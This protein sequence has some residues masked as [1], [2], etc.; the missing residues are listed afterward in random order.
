[1]NQLVFR[2]L[3]HALGPHTIDRFA[4]R[5]NR[6]LV[7][8]NSLYHD[9]LS[10]GD[11]F[12]VSQTAWR[13]EHSW[14]NPPFSLLFRLLYLLWWTGGS[15]TVIAPI[16]PAQPWYPL[17]LRLATHVIVLP[18]LTDLFLPGYSGSVRPLKNP[19]W[20]VAAW[21]LPLRPPRTQVPLRILRS[22]P[23]TELHTCC[24]NLT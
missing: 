6:L 2:Q 15:A 16:W 19:A 21:R 13:H 14:C 5:E 10:E 11:V 17:L 8:F 4:S 7:R 12:L 18:S 1:M 20:R 23:W 24:A 3:D 22:I 9:P